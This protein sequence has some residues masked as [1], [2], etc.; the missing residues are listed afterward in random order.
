MSFWT[1]MGQSY[2]FQN[3]VV[4]LLYGTALWGLWG[5]SKR[6]YWKQAWRQM[7]TNRLAMVSMVILMAFTTI[8]TLDSIG[9]RDPARNQKGQILLNEKK[10][11]VYQDRG[12][13]VFDRL[14][15][16][17]RDRSEKT[18]SAPL[19]EYQFTKELIQ[20]A[21]GVTRQDYPKLKHPRSHILGTDKVGMDVLYSALKGVRTALLIGIV[22][23]MIVTPFA[24]FFGVLAGFY[25]GWVDDVVQYVYSTL[26]SIPGILLIA[27]FMLIAGRGLMQLC[28]ILGITS[29]TGLC[30][31]LRGETL[32]LRELEYVQA[33]TALGASRWGIIWKH[34]V[35]NLMHIVL[36]TMV[37]RFSGLV[38]S[39]A[40]LSFIGI[41]VDPQTGSW[42]RMINEA[43]LELSR[44]PVVWWNLMAAFV[45]MFGLIL[46]ANLFG[47]A[48][49][50]ALDPRLKT[51]GER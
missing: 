9:W 23:T 7:K 24:I 29:W 4:A 17:L 30:R 10:E 48:V 11:V 40:V 26:S 15:K 32:K 8:A 27:A 18:Y 42:G 36:I 6:E 2:P 16:R 38:L 49:R 1:W 21:D 19:A 20:G 47:D 14:F 5:A 39:E 43:R 3:T 51:G 31:L 50:D 22:T 28:L 13:T 33:A 35:P 41:G 25:G 34:I 44:E 45:F 46:P 12:L 37:L